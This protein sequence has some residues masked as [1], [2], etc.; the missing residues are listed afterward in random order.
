[1]GLGKTLETLA[2]TVGNPPS[3]DDLENGLFRTLIVVPANAVN[4]WID[5]IYR[6]GDNLHAAQYKESARH[7]MAQLN[8]CNIW[9]VSYQEVSSHYPTNA[10]IKAREHDDSLSKEDCDARRMKHSGPL[11]KM[12]FLRVILDEAHAIKNWQSHS[13]TMR[14]KFF[15]HALFKLPKPRV[16]KDVKVPMS[17]EE[18]IIYRHVSLLALNTNN[19]DIFE[20][21]FRKRAVKDLDKPL[22]PGFVTNWLLYVLRLRQ[23]VAH[24]FLLESLMRQEFEAEDYVWLKGELSQIRTDRPLILQIGSWCEEEQQHRSDIEHKDIDAAGLNAQFDFLPQLQKLERRKEMLDK[25]E[26]G[27]DTSDMVGADGAEQ[28]ISELCKRCGLPP[29]SGFSPKCGHLF[30][31]ECIEGHITA[32]AEGVAQGLDCSECSRL[33][34]NIKSSMRN[35]SSGQPRSSD[36]NVTNSGSGRRARKRKGRGRGDDVNGLQPTSSTKLESLLIQES[37]KKSA[38]ELTPSAKTIV[39]KNIIMDWR[40][41]Y[42]GD[43]MI[44]FTQ[45]VD[46]GRIIGRI[47]QKEDIP[48]LYFFGSMS[49]TQKYQAQEDFTKKEEIGILALNLA[50]A[51]RIFILDLWWNYAMEQQA[52]GRV[53]RMGQTKRTV[54][55]RIMVKNTIDERMAELQAKKIKAI[56][57]AIRDHDSSRMVLTNEEV[58]GLLGRVIFDEHGRMK[59]IVSDYDDESDDSYDE[60]DEE[61]DS[62]DDETRSEISSQGSG[63][64]SSGTQ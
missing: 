28:D 54:R 11:M 62:S 57:A 38:D 12:K 26:D 27:E 15:G 6:H 33:V 42:P 46:M 29:D 9:L 23:A 32:M 24:P 61:E 59:D 50:C 21:K 43:K 63:R 64:G 18:T 19:T 36:E 53:Y 58:A 41:R 8:S 10:A 35:G 47:L 2:C 25:M 51:N 49:Q 48:F 60:S 16:L 52:F 14:T 17:R 13:E 56:D 4:Q 5:E 55:A 1:M 39:L 22:G 20:D 3:E 40:S 34:S 37:D 44:I 31:Q 30:C 7:R 45:F